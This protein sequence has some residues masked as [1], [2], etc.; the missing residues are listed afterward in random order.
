MLPFSSQVTPKKH[1][2]P[3]TKTTKTPTQYPSNN[4]PASRGERLQT[5]VVVWKYAFGSG[6]RQLKKFGLR[7]DTHVAV[8]RRDIEG[9]ADLLRPLEGRDARLP[10]RSI[11][12]LQVGPLSRA[13]VRGRRRLARPDLCFSVVTAERTLDFEALTQEDFEAVVLGLQGRFPK[14]QRY[15]GLPLYT[16]AS[17]RRAC[18]MMR[19]AVPRFPPAAF[20]A[21]G[22][23]A[24]EE[25][26]RKGA[27]VG[28]DEE[29]AAVS[30]WAGA[31]RTHTEA[32][33]EDGEEAGGGSLSPAAL[34]GYP[35]GGSVGGG[36]GFGRS[37]VLRTPAAPV[38]VDSGAQTCGAGA[39]AAEGFAGGG[40]RGGVGGGGCQRSVLGGG[41][42]GVLRGPSAVRGGGGGGGGGFDSYSGTP[43]VGVVVDIDCAAFPS[44]RGVG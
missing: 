5:G 27:T 10:V 23:D 6:A 18:A 12:A 35:A 29:D 44:S 13:H 32:A 42:G 2:R 9:R 7:G 28:E 1:T 24:Y 30:E 8:S 41:G 16:P 14:A 43:V 25:A 17:L 34:R 21:G 39:E 22:G 3:T 20:A 36:G 15:A 37:G 31:A 26:L 4:T 40:G 19:D 11:L 33:F 38:A